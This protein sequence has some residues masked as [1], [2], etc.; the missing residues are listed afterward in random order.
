[1][2]SQSLY[3]SLQLM[4]NNSNVNFEYI[5]KYCKKKKKKN[6]G[7]YGDTETARQCRPN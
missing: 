6:Q 2:F 1:M 5:F 3:V 4:Q 7:E